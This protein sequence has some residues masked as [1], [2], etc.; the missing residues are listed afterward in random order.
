MKNKLENIFWLLMTPFI[1][2]TILI[3]GTIEKIVKGVSK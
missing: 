3:L 1:V 2:I